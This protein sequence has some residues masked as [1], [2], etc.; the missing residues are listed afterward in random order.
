MLRNKVPSRI[1][2]TALFLGSLGLA[3]LVNGSADAHPTTSSCWEQWDSVFATSNI[4][5]KGATGDINWSMLNANGQVVQ[6]TPSPS[7]PADTSACWQWRRRCG[8]HYIRVEAPGHIHG[9]FD[10]W[11]AQ[12]AVFCTKNGLTGF[13]PAGTV[14]PNCPNWAVEPREDFKPHDF[15]TDLHV[16]VEHL[17]SH[18][19]HLFDLE[20]V[21]NSGS[22]PMRLSVKDEAGTWWT[23]VLGPNAIGPNGEEY[24]WNVTDFGWEITQAR[25][26]NDNSSG[27]PVTLGGVY[28][29]TAP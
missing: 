29:S 5:N 6:C 7:I 18:G 17:S 14:S 1:L 13:A 2:R 11:P 4:Y 20:Y 27:P 10:N 8:E 19:I 28:F 21:R 15:A 25:M 22:T 12:N 9:W 24:Y 16:W 26:R 23:T 3:V